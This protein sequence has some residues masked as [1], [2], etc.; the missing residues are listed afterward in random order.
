M[1]VLDGNTTYVYNTDGDLLY[2]CNTGTGSKKIV[3]T[4]DST[5]YVLSVNQVRFLDLKNPPSTADTV[6]ETS[7]E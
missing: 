1:A 5:A 7:E 6:R 3:L 4:S 2:S